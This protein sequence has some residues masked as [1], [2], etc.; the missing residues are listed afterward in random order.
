MAFK[1]NG[2][3]S[4]A[5]LEI[6]NYINTYIVSIAELSNYRP[7][8]FISTLSKVIERVVLKRMMKYCEIHS[9]I[10]NRQHGFLEG[11]S[12]TS[13]IIELTEFIIGNIEAGKLV[14]GVLSDVSKV[15]DGLRHDL[16]LRTL[17]GLGIMGNVWGKWTKT[18]IRSTKHGKLRIT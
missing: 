4:T 17:S 2:H 5:A 16:I 7:I 18:N 13:S 10:T 14:T 8:S 15:F 6:V 11:K 1:M 3:I 12:T 9:L